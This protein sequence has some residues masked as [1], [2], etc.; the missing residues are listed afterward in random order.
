MDKSS[1]RKAI[2]DGGA[3]LGKA[4]TA[5][6]FK[7]AAAL[8]TEDAQ[9]LAP[10]AAVVSG[11]RAIEAFWKQAAGA[12]GLEKATLQTVE[13]ES[14]GDLAV[15]VGTARLETAGGVANVKYVVSWRR[16][17][18]GAWRLHRDIWNGLPG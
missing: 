3:A 1:A 12:L 7:A 2:E 6:D 15:E 18:D 16:G 10:D 13:V 5:K 9:V 8:Y 11:R 14:S 4:L 17:G